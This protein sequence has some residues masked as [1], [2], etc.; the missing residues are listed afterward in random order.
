MI[1]FFLRFTSDPLVGVV[2]DGRL[3]EERYSW[4]KA[5]KDGKSPIL[6]QQLTSVYLTPKTRVYTI[7][8]EIAPW[9]NF[10][11]SRHS[12]SIEPRNLIPN[13]LAHPVPGNTIEAYTYRSLYL[14]SPQF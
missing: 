7:C 11:A 3:G 13:N 12:V 2:T 1:F 6:S 4:K 9:A 10:V 14:V 5:Q 8:S